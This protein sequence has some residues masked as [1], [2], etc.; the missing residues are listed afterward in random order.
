MVQSVITLNGT[1][2]N[3]FVKNIANEAN[4]G[5]VYCEACNMTMMGNNTFEQNGI[6]NLVSNGGA[7]SVIS[8]GRLHFKPG[9]TIFLRNKAYQGGAILTIFTSITCD[10]G[11]VII[12]DGNM[13]YQNGGGNIPSEFRCTSREV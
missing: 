10:A 1:P 12:I 6:L 11:A 5:A 7:V 4:G 2:E 9:K 3:I 8:K 13:A